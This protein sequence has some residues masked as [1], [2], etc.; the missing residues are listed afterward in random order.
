MKLKL[1]LV[2]LNFKKLALAFLLFFQITFCSSQNY[3]NAAAY[4]NDFGR[5][6]TFINA[7]M[8]EYSKTIALMS[9]ENRVNKSSTELVDKLVKLNS[10]LETHDKGFKN[11]T[12]LRDAMMELNTAVSVFMTSDASDFNDYKEQ[13]IFEFDKINENFEQKKLEIEKL[14]IKFKNYENIK[15]EF[16]EQYG[17]PIKYY[18]GFNIYEYN[19]YQNLIYY[20]INVL[21]EKLMLAITNRDVS[22]I[23]ACKTQIINICNESFQKTKQYRSQYFDETLNTANILLTDFFLYQDKTLLPIAIEFFEFSEQFQNLKCKMVEDSAYI[24][25][26][27]YNNQVRTYNTL[28]NIFYDTLY[29]IKLKKNKLISGWV[30]TNSSFL[31]NN[32]SFDVTDFKFVTETD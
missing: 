8:M 32:C 25:I 21:D 28:K 2:Y 27:E 16:G 23:E 6:E 14:Y 31:K 29:E 15:K 4:I 17:I 19:T 22:T 5:N 10:V 7:T 12:R 30:I 24:T 3:R 1:F 11:D 20:K 9:P 13:S 18:T 26:E